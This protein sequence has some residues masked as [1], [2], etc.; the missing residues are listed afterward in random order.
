MQLLFNTNAP[1]RSPLDLHDY[2]LWA[3]EANKLNEHAVVIPTYRKLRKLERALT[4]EHLNRTNQ[5]LTHLPLFTMPSFASALYEKLAPGRR[6]AS[7]EIQIA[8]MERAMKSVDLNYYA[9]PGKDPS[10]GVVEQITRVISGVR[11]DGILPTHF[12][13][14]IE[15]VKK[16][17]EGLAGYDVVKLQDLYNIYSEYLRILGDTWIDYPGKMLRVNTELFRDKDAVFRKAFPNVQTLLIHDH[18]EFTQPEIDMLIQLG[19]VQDLNVLILF[20][21]NDGNGPLYGNFGEVVDKL[22]TANYGQ[23]NLDPLEANIPEE[24][25][26]PFTHH[27]RKNL[28]RTDR[29][30]ENSAFDSKIS[31]YSFHSREEE[32]RGIAGLVKSLVMEEGIAPEQICVTTLVMEPYTEL[33]REYFPSYG[34]P[35]NITAR[36]ALERNGLITALFSALNIL[37]ENYDRRDV[38][39]AV[40]SP[41]LTFGPDV[42][43]A[44]LADA[45]TKL[46]ITR[47]YQAWKRRIGRR[48]DYLNTRQNTLLDADE[49]RTIQLELETL[50]RAETS[51]ES[52]HHTLADFS[53]Q[54]TPTEF[55]GAFLKLIA[56]LRATENV[57]ELRR[58]LDQHQRNP[59]DWQRIHDE[60]E[61]DTRALARFLG[62]LDELTELFELDAQEAAKER[63]DEQEKAQNEQN[64]EQ[65]AEED[66]EGAEEK[67]E[68]ASVSTTEE[69]EQKQAE[70][71]S[72]SLDEDADERIHRLDYYLSHLRTAAAR[73]YYTIREKHDYGILVT[74]LEQIQGLQY[75]VVIICGLVDGEFPSTYIPANFLGKPLEKTEERQLRRERIAF[76]TGLTASTERIYLTYPR[77]SGENERV[78][79][80]FLDALLRITTVEKS[81]RLHEFKEL[82]IERDERRVAE[83]TTPDRDFPALIET[84][85]ALAEEAGKALWHGNPLPRIQDHEGNEMLEHLKHTVSVE[86]AR[87][88]AVNDPSIVP[89]YRGIIG[90]ALGAEER[91]NLAKRRESEYSASQ[92]ELYARCPFKYFTRRLLGIDVPQEYDV[93]LTPLER[94]FLLHTVLFRL[95]SELRD[96]GELPIS[97]ENQREAL[98]RAQ[99]IAG[100]EIEGIALDHPYWKIDR[101][102]LLGS[103]AL[104]GLLEQWIE[105]EVHRAGE[106]TELV[107]EFFEV[108]FGKS[109]SGSTATDSLLSQSDEIELYNIK[110]RGKVDRVEVLRQGDDVY[111]AVADYK[112]GQP[113]SRGDIENGLSLQLMLYLEVVRQILAKHFDVPLENVKPAGGI[114]YRLNARQVNTKDTY[115]LVPN[116]L[117][118]DL[119][120]ERKYKR[121]PDTVEALEERMEEAFAFAEQYV[122]G[123]ATGNYHVTTHDVNKV[124][125]GCEYHSVCRVWEVGRPEG[126]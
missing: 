117:K 45:A 116:E 23:T 95:Y 99:E 93:S 14:D 8:L 44:A 56:K 114:Y 25:R 26:R 16:D 49:R 83:P 46:R 105:S 103:E 115:L 55:R 79:S 37:A 85:E 71:K 29:R 38:L 22:R 98:H 100:E 119:I 65:G 125:R 76:Y 120:K 67:N 104:N 58:S 97:E 126:E 15:A 122:E 60:M 30:I 53:L 42:D 73:S 109:G 121:D 108:G 107:P 35:A 96:K 91:E 33:F 69:H 11:A 102:R 13:D 118:G 18:T 21:Y 123:I 87:R 113:P 111:Y 94:G 66:R 20:D 57:L 2:I 39:R 82:R 90:Q 10:L 28:F 88:D 63:A 78:R 24:E 89:E 4:D 9:R 6:E 3:A 19:M 43:P 52:I 17:P 75:D 81:N 92:L 124:C 50:K 1:D 7:M 77:T 72:T 80:S 48:I 110:V 64:T 27:M 74:P 34:I 59:A 54:L 5:P 51:I 101:E 68:S 62:L 36:F 106:K 84:Q 31:A 61:R 86:M 41:Y 32:A 112:T 70:E 40:T 47:G 12:S